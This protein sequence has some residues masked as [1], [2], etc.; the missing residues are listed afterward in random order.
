VQHTTGSCIVPGSVIHSV[1]LQFY[2]RLLALRDTPGHPLIA[3]Y[4]NQAQESICLADPNASST[5]HTTYKD[6]SKA[7]NK[8]TTLALVQRCRISHL[9][10]LPLAGAFCGLEAIA[11]LHNALSTSE[12]VKFSP[13]TLSSFKTITRCQ[14]NG[15]SSNT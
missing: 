13:P 1:V 7:Y 6:R 8:Q 12:G 15:K 5:C 11:E 9:F 2:T 14:P 10:L 4:Y 3:K